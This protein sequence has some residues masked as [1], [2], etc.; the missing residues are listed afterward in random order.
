MRGTFVLLKIGD[1]LDS[2]PGFIS[3]IGFSW[4]TTYPWQAQTKQK[5][6]RGSNEEDGLYEGVPLLPHVLDVSCNFTPIHNFIPQTNTNRDL[7]DF[8]YI[9]STDLNNPLTL[10]SPPDNSTSTVPEQTPQELGDTSTPVTTLTG[11][12]VPRTLQ[13][14]PYPY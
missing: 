14:I 3:S 7:T 10:V 9:A 4:N 5:F 1:Y 6:K 2:T 13:E 8:A 12:E 11:L